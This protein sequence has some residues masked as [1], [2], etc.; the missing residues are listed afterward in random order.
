MALSHRSTTRARVVRATLCC[1][2]L[3]CFAATTRAQ[4]ARPSTSPPAK[5]DSGKTGSAPFFTATDAL[6]GAGFVL[7]TVAMFPLDEHLAK[8]LQDSTTQANKFANNA[9]KTFEWF[10]SS[11]AYIIGGSLYVVGWATHHPEIRD[12]G[13]HGTEAVIFA[14]VTTGILK[15]VLG[16]A[17]PF[18][19]GDTVP[20]DF[21]LGGGFSNSDRTSFPSGHTTTAFAAAA[22][23]TSEARRHW[24]DRWWSTWLLG[25]TMYGGATMVGIARMYHNKHWASDVVMGAAIGTVS[26]YKVVDYSHAN[27]HNVVDRVMLN[28]SAAPSP[29]GGVRIG[30]VME[31]P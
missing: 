20:R 7:G 5:A 22:A 30:Y 28:V 18:A 13:W 11:G 4:G 1:T 9:A 26:G 17:R 12:L 25:T 29:D 10:G 6:V 24:P 8:R 19:T 23:V 2:L 3:S 16:R 14:Q 27:P 15:G 31:V 21:K